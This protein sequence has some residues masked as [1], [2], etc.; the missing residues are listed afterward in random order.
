[1]RAVNRPDVPLLSPCG[2]APEEKSPSNKG[3]RPM[4]AHSEK[5][6]GP[7][8]KILNGVGCSKGEKQN[9]NARRKSQGNGDP[10]QCIDHY[11]NCPVFHH[12]NCNWLRTFHDTFLVLGIPISCSL[13]RCVAAQALTILL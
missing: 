8:I 9:A 11:V 1:M 13:G 3:P 4:L 7:G 10:A 2:S 6:L 5:C 12:S